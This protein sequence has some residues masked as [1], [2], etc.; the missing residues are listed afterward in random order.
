MSRRLDSVDNK[1]KLWLADYGWIITLVL[2]VGTL[3]LG[4]LANFLDQKGLVV[5]TSASLGGL[6]HE[7]VQSKGTIVLPTDRDDGIYLGSAFGLVL[8]ATAGVVAL[9]AGQPSAA[10]AFLAGLALK[11]VSEAAAGTKT[12]QKTSSKNS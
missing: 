3:A 10:S 7:L 12:S 2:T 6:A 1:V 5:V 9:Q 8:G 4:W 11:G